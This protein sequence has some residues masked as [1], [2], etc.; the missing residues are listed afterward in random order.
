M[1][2]LISG[3]YTLMS[4]NHPPSMSK[5]IGASVRV[6]QNFPKMIFAL[7]GKFISFYAS[8]L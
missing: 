8:N 3:C 6:I 4:V 5:F 1:E 7:L 2:I